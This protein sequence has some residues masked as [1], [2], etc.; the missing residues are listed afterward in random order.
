MS[1]PFRVTLGR[2]DWRQDLGAWDCAA[3]RVPGARIHSVFEQ[4]RQLDPAS[5]TLVDGGLL[6][7]TPTSAAPTEITVLISLTRAPWNH[8]LTWKLAT[9]AASFVATVLSAEV[10]SKLAHACGG[11]GDEPPF[12]AA[13]PHHQVPPSPASSHAA[14][15][16]CRDETPPRVEPNREVLDSRCPENSDTP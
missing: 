4:G 5:Y 6:R 15:A 3:L 9:V 10:T 16:S 11:Q 8:A 7:W 2:L 12:V 14:P 13:P 1:T